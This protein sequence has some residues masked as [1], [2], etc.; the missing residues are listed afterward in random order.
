MEVAATFIKS[1]LP[2]RNHK[3]LKLGRGGYPQVSEALREG[4]LTTRK[5]Y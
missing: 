5:K 3:K 2:G 1:G 4:D